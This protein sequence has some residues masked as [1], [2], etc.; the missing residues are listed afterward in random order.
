MNYLLEIRTIVESIGVAQTV[1]WLVLVGIGAWG[2]ISGVFQ[3]LI[4][5]GRGLAKRKIAIFA[6]GDRIRSIRAL[7]LDSKLF[8]LKNIV[9]ITSLNDLGIAERASVFLIFWD[10]WKADLEKILYY[11]KDSTALLV[12]APIESG[13]ISEELMCRIGEQ[14]NVT[15]T[16][17]RGR[18]LNDIVISM[19]TTSYN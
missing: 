10:D 8:K 19:I 18:L 13:N 3:V 16:R 14:R 12:Y 1:V 15:V 2:T 11:K 17:F 4:R 5:I 7:L 6:K 9:E